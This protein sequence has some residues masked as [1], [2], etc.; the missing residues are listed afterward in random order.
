MEI[1]HVK[2]PTS[3]YD[4]VIYLCNILTYTFY[5]NFHDGKFNDVEKILIYRKKN[6]KKN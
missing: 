5:N 6:Q 2:F 1:I 4:D 3:V